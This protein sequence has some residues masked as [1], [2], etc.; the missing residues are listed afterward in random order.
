MCGTFPTHILVSWLSCEHPLVSPGLQPLLHLGNGADVGRDLLGDGGQ[1][2]ILLLQ[3]EKVMELGCG[4][5]G[6]STGSCCLQV[7]TVKPHTI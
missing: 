7:L 4:S 6:Q 1:V 2:G 3:L 5:Q